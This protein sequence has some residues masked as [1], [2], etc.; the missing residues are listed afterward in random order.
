MGPDTI[1]VGDVTAPTPSYLDK[2]VDLR[3]SKESFELNNTA[4]LW[5]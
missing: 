1:V 5:I 3:I 4:D 2:P